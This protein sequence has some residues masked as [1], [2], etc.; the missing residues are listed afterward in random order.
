[1]RLLPR[2]LSSAPQ[3]TERYRSG[4]GVGR[5]AVPRLR[6]D[7][8]VFGVEPQKFTDVYEGMIAGRGVDIGDLL[9]V[10]VDSVSRDDGRTGMVRRLDGV[11]GD[12]EGAV[13]GT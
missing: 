8:H 1:M 12:Q 9:A 10:R 13:L 7:R 6:P 5:L 11:P 4:D 3:H 2:P